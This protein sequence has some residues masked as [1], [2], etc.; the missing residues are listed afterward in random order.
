MEYTR[1]GNSDLNISRICMGLSLIH[2]YY[3]GSEARQAFKRKY[4]FSDRCRYYLPDSR[5]QAAEAR[6]LA[7]LSETGIPLSLLSQF[8]PVQYPRVREGRLS[9]TPEALLCDRIENCIDDY[10][11]A[12]GNR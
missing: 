9:C 7:N 3:H 6:L 2:I 10:L 4:S 5:V 1:L 12:T 8:M 11:F